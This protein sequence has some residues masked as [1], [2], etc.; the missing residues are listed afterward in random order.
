MINEGISLM[1]GDLEM[2]LF[3]GQKPGRPEKLDTCVST[4]AGIWFY[5]GKYSV[6][7]LQM[8]TLR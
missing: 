4:T 2:T 3:V 7:A 1:N 6:K 8:E 5:Q